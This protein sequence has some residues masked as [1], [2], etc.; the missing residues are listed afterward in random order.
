MKDN[1][2]GTGRVYTYEASTGLFQPSSDW[3]TVD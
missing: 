2:I 3:F 1:K